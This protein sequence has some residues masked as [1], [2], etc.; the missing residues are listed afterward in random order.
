V[1][2]AAASSD[3]VFQ[4][5]VRIPTSQSVLYAPNFLELCKFAWVQ[6]LAAGPRIHPY[7]FHIFSST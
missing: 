5:R 6:I 4:A 1:W 7:I 3:F 2:E